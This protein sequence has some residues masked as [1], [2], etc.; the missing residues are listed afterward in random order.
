MQAIRSHTPAQYRVPYT[1][2]VD[3][4]QDIAMSS[5]ERCVLQ[6]Y[7][8][9]IQSCAAGHQDKASKALATLID[10]LNFDEG[11]EIATGLFRLYD[12]CLRMVH[13]QRFDISQSILKG[14]RDTWQTGLS[15]QTATQSL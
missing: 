4:E 9:A 10:E 11:G 5:S 3:K 12:Y 2:Q 1:V 7:D 13:K 15:D 6:L 8:V 14:L